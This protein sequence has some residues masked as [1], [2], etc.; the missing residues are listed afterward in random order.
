MTATIPTPD[1]LA[2]QRQETIAVA[3]A[4]ARTYVITYMGKADPNVDGKIWIPLSNTL[5][6][7]SEP[8]IRAL[9]A[10]LIAKGWMVT[11]ESSQM[12]ESY[13]ILTPAAGR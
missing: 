7:M 9:T 12:N 6:R 3:L 5:P 1:Q 13:L 10:E 11:R 4:D 8:V 2:A